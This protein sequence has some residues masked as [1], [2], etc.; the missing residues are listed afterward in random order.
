MLE[1]VEAV[2][3]PLEV[4]EALHA[5]TARAAD[6]APEESRRAYARAWSAAT[7][8]LGELSPCEVS[9]LSEEE[10]WR[11]AKEEIGRS[12]ESGGDLGL[13][14]LLT[15][16]VPNITSAIRR[17]GRLLVDRELTAKILELRQEKAASHDGRWPEKLSDP[18]SSVCPGAS[19]EYQSRGAAMAIRFK[20]AIDDGGGPPLVLPL[21]FEVR[22]PIPTPTP[23]K[24]RRSTVTPRPRS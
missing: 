19:Y 2:H 20:G 24:A 10:I 12:I 3:P 14:T 22:A 17:A 21:S 9:K 6:A 11:P 8:R 15:I 7:Y 16:A 13:Q 18:E 4:L 23:V 1:V 5:P